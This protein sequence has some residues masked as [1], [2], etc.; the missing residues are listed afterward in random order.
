MLLRQISEDYGEKILKLTQPQLLRVLEEQVE[1]ML[2]S[3][4]DHTM[5]ATDFLAAYM[6]HYG[7]S[8]DLVQFGV[9]DVVAAHR[10]DS[11]RCTGAAKNTRHIFSSK[12]GFTINRCFQVHE[13]EGK[14]VLSLIDNSEMER[15]A[16][17]VVCLLMATSECRL[18]CT[19]LQQ[20]HQQKY[21]AELT[22]DDL[23]RLE[24]YGE[25]IQVRYKSRVHS[26]EK[27]RW[28]QSKV[29]MPYVCCTP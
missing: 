27:I 1:A 26:V 3:S 4:A 23:Q 25:F 13:V 19:D 11:S 17:R 16:K 20:K 18:P 28:Y 21:E 10:Q 15:L 22:I 24:D 2:K 7:N 14:L 12:L 8:L 6:H 9:S 29:P 5:L